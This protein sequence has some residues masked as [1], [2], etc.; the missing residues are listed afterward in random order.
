MAPPEC[1]WRL[2][3]ARRLC[4]CHQRSRREAP[5]SSTLAARRLLLIRLCPDLGRNLGR[6]AEFGRARR[7]GHRLETKFIGRASDSAAGRAEN[8]AAAKLDRT[9]VCKLHYVTLQFVE[10][11]KSKMANHATTH[12]S[13]LEN[14]VLRIVCRRRDV[15]AEEV[16]KAL[17]RSRRFKD[18]TTR[19][20]LRRLEKKG[21][22]QHS[23][24][25]RTFRFSPKVEPQSVAANALRRI[26][27]CFCDGSAESLVRTLVASGLISAD[28]LQRLA[29]TMAADEIVRRRQGKFRHKD[30]AR[31]PPRTEDSATE[32]RE[33]LSSDSVTMTAQPKKTRQRILYKNQLRRPGTRKGVKTRAPNWHSIWKRAR[34]KAVRTTSQSF[35]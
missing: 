27:K 13:P 25:G 15:T 32:D 28:E 29:I 16:G 23:I 22:I 2:L 5:F 35:E 6:R 4:A 26:I 7:L 21:L 19:T 20:L 10:R 33:A 34:D 14:R 1:Y 18:S 17:A 31:R 9:A 24:E 12:P 3:L 11:G 30:Q 8:S